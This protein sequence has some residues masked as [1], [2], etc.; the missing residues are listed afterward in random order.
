MRPPGVLLLVCAALGCVPA[1][2]QEPAGPKPIASPTPDELARG[3]QIFESGC[4]RCHG[5]TGRGGFGPSLVRPRL[6]RAPDDAALLALVQNGIPNTAMP[7]AWDLDDREA[8]LVGAYV[9]SLGKLPAEAVSGDPVRG[10]AVYEGKG[11]C[12]ACHILAG[13]GRGLGPELTEIG[14]LRGTLYLREAI[15]DPGKALPDRPVPYEPGAYAGYLVTRAILGDGREVLGARVN[16]DTFT[17]QLR[18]AAG[19]LHSLRKSELRA[20][21][22][23]AGRSLMPAYGATLAPAE[24]DDLVAYLAGLRGEP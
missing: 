6:R 15:L 8:A 18:D 7:G 24:V 22:K 3:R 2:G 11:G 13:V 16:E 19:L 4:A 9:R 1:Q 5:I 12:A 21:E 14:A 17:I 10:R 23:Q 20:L